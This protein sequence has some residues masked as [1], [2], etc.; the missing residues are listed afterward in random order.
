M[1]I[2]IK[3]LISTSSKLSRFFFI[4]WNPLKVNT[5]GPKKSIDFIH[6]QETSLKIGFLCFESIDSGL[7]L[8]CLHFVTYTIA[9]AW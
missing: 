7:P 8:Q 4:L 3:I 9:M 2:L 5:L 6:F 1:H